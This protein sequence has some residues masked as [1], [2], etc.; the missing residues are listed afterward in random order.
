MKH[1]L[2]TW[3]ETDGND[4]IVYDTIVAAD[5]EELAL[6][7]LRLAVET[8]YDGL[9]DD[10]SE[11]G[12]YFDDADGGLVLRDVQEFDSRAA[13]EAQCSIW[14]VRFDVETEA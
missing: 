12:Y 8:D 13:A 9:Q 5:S 2:I 14:H 7:T 6:D 11:F 4:C 10:G 1:Y 3:H